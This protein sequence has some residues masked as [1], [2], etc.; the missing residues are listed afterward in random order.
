MTILNRLRAAVRKIGEKRSPRWP[1]LEKAF[2]KTNSVC[3]ACGSNKHLNV[4]HKQ[5][6]HIDPALE[7]DV[8]NLITLCMNKDCHLLLGHGDDFK[9]YN[10]DVVNDV[11]VVHQDW[12]RF[13]EVVAEVKKKR[14][15]K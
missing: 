4:H 6:F 7:L 5:P 10:P 8:T 15:Y 11:S 12:S 1:A 14:Q 2:L 9:A 3:A 13:A